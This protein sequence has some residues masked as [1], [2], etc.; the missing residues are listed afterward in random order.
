MP[1]FFPKRTAELANLENVEFTEGAG[2][3][4]SEKTSG[5][6]R[7]I[8][9]SSKW[10][11]KR[12]QELAELTEPDTDELLQLGKEETSPMERL[13]E[14]SR[15]VLGQLSSDSFEAKKPAIFRNLQ[16]PVLKGDESSI[17]EKVEDIPNERY[18]F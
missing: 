9:S 13:K 15:K 4:P 2:A 11:P 14:K 17:Y 18:K 5:E 16:S 8:K 3:E 12:T 6:L 1:A 7:E 10:A